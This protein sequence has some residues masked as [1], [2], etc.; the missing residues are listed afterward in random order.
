MH[1]GHSYMSK[2]KPA[3]NATEPWRT[4]SHPTQHPTPPPK[5][6]KHWISENPNCFLL[7]LW[8]GF[9]YGEAAQSELF[10]QLPLEL[11]KPETAAAVQHQPSHIWFWNLSVDTIFTNSKAQNQHGKQIQC[12]VYI[13]HQVHVLVMNYSLTDLNWSWN[14]LGSQ[15]HGYCLWKHCRK[16]LWLEFTLLNETHISL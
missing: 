11:E 4:S 13:V 7:T 9:L 14:R 12:T 3:A 8:S 15:G 10:M 1:S 5:R 2:D 6:R 16:G